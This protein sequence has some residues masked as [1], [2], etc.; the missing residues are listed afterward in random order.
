MVLRRGTLKQV[1][2]INRACDGVMWDWWEMQSTL[3]K[4]PADMTS[5][6]VSP[7]LHHPP[8]EKEHHRTT[9]D[10]SISQMLFSTQHLHQHGISRIVGVVLIPVYQQQKYYSLLTIWQMTDWI[11]LNCIPY[12]LFYYWRCLRNKCIYLAETRLQSDYLNTI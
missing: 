9:S 12:S 1:W 8:L 11:V 6:L 10:E 7:T 4:S 5:T 3:T 2:V